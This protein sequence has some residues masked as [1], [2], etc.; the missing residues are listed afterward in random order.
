LATFHGAIQV[1]KR[2][3]GVW[4]TGE[5]QIPGVPDARESRIPGVPEA[6]ESRIPGVLDTGD[7]FFYCFLN[8]KP[9]YLQLGHRE[10]GNPDAGESRIPGVPDAWESRITGVSDTGESFFEFSVFFKLQPIATAFNPLTHGI[11]QSCPGK[12]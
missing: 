4:D 6:R 1:L 3:P 7:S 9:T 11:K 10:F 2:L 5:L 12:V 8:L